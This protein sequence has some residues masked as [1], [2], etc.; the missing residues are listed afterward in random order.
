MRE[1]LL[2]HGSRTRAVSVGV[3]LVMVGLAL[4]G[5]SRSLAA[6]DIERELERQL[7]TQDFVPDVT[8][9][10]DLPGEVGATITCDTILAD[11]LEV[12][13]TVTATHVQGD[14]VRYEFAVEATGLGGSGGES[15]ANSVPTSPASTGSVPTRSAP[16]SDSP[17]T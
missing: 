1:W 15:P 6:D 3:C 5:C 7:S 16:T 11:G 4:A 2:E 9:A 14:Q 17:S 10:D 12:E 13:I 8:C